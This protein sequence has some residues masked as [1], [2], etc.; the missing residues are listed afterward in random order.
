MN[1][2]EFKN[3][4]KAASEL[5][6]NGDLFI[7][8]A[9]ERPD[10]DALGSMLALGHGLKE[11]GK[12]FILYSGDELPKGLSFMP[13]TSMLTSNIP[14]KLTNDFVLVLLDCH[15]PER[16]GDMGQE[17]FKKAASVLI[18]DHHLGEG[19]CDGEER[20]CI[21]IIDPSKCATAQIC[22]ELFKELSWP[23]SKEMASCIYTA[24]LTD[25]GGFRYSN[26][27]EDTFELAKEL[28]S[29][30]ANPYEIAL[31]CF[32]TKPL[33]KLKLLGLALETLEVHFKG[34]LSIMTLT[35]QMFELCGSKE[36]ETDDFVSYARA[37]DTVEVAI[38]IKETKPG[39]V[40]VSLRSKRFVNV[41]EMASH[42]GGGGHFNAAGFKVEGNPKE[43]KKQVIALAGTYLNK[44]SYG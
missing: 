17:L 37:I 19:P 4:L 32:E 5:I 3:Q 26:T 18:L 35:P 12:E 31:S 14:E 13:G 16:P 33:T 43:I 41:A 39:L 10:G 42:F 7:V 30:G 28:V 34:L 2:V 40:S 9:H 1:K 36:S 11:A 23:I 15:E 8:T 20:T 21:S 25:T 44:D 6:K 38:L 22:F 24:V 27:K 29:L